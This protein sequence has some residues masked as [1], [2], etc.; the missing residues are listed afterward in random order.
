MSPG[1]SRLKGIQLDAT[2]M[3]RTRQ[4]RMWA[5]KKCGTPVEQKRGALQLRGTLH[6]RQEAAKTTWATLNSGVLTRN[7]LQHQQDNPVDM[8]RGHQ[9]TKQQTRGRIGDDTNYMKI[10]E[11]STSGD[12]EIL[13]KRLQPNQR[14]RSYTTPKGRTRMR[15]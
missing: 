7:T 9:G 4:L 3:Q 2:C 8:R 15:T 6:L 11:L 13:V 1:T 10:W 12:R 14:P 5:T